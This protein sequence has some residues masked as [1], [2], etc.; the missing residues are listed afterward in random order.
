MTTSAQHLPAA[1][2]KPAP[3]RTIAPHG[4]TL[5]NRIV[6][7]ERRE[8]ARKEAASLRVIPLNA[9][10]ASDA[11]LIATGGFSPLEGFLGYESAKS[12]VESMSLRNGTLWPLPVLLQLGRDQTDGIRFGTRVALSVEG[13]CVTTLEV[14]DRFAVPGR[15]W[16]AKI[17]GTSDEAHPGVAALLS[18]GEI[19]L[20]GTLEW[21]S[22]PRLAGLPAEWQTPSE[23]RAEITRRGWRTVAG[24]QTRNPVHRAHEYVLRTAIE[25][26][27]GLLL[28]PL[29]GETKAEDLP[30]PLRLRCYRA[31]LDNYLPQERV[32]FAVMPAWMRYAGPREAIFHALVRK[33]FGCTHFLVGRDHAGVGS[34]YG[35]YDAHHLL[36]SVA[37][38]GLD[39]QPI[40][41]DEVFYCTRCGSMASGRTCAHPKEDHLGLSGTEVR[42]R[43]REGLPLPVEFTRP[44]VA[45][46]LAEAFRQPAAVDQPAG[47][48]QPVAPAQPPEEARA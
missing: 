27:D 2:D 41:F 31:L 5:V 46:I 15:D 42:R 1:T 10:A 29:V 32:L 14:T 33:N 47:N 45:A 18:S 36:R 13:E 24:F 6:A 17:Y 38:R 22:E 43:L 4:G 16:A 26:T 37:G 40:F 3:A 25:V 28:H 19:A 34:Y 21:F 30:A 9:R 48:R 11:L 23:V 8:E 35:P 44:E 7:Q 39:I 20:G 12:V